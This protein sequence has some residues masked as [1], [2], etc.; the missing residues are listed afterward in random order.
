MVDVGPAV[1]GT[2]VESPGEPDFGHELDS[3]RFMDAPAHFVDEIV[4][5]LRTGSPA[6][7]KEVRME[8][9]HCCAA[10]PESLEPR[11]L[12]KAPR[13]VAGWILEDASC[14]L[15]R[16]RLSRRPVLPVALH[17]RSDGLGVLAR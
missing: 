8:L 7:H 4:D 13:V 3:E 15:Q 11:C 6:R 1:I 17:S 5:I 14:V 16:S 10:D 12:N 9:R 2:R